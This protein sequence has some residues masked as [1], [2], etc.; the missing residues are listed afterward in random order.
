MC[1]F[2]CFDWEGLMTA[3]VSLGVLGLFTLL[4]DLYLTLVGGI[5]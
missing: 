3:S 1:L 2:A 5:Y 4:T